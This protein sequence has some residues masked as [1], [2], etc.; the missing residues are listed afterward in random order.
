DLDKTAQLS[1][2][3]SSMIVLTTIH[4]QDFPDVDGDFI[5][6]RRTIP[7]VFPQASRIITPL[8]MI[9]WTAILNNAWQL[10][11]VISTVMY[12]LGGVVAARI[13]ANRS[14]S[15]DRRTYLYYNVSIVHFIC[16]PRLTIPQIW[17]FSAHLL[18]ANARFGILSW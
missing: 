8:I 10:G 2:V 12:I 14:T 11:P 3:L 16:S 7:I 13:Y 5:L 18:P 15:G 1:V 9:G 17:L 4:V 6:G